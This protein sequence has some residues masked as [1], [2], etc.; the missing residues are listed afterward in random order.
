MDVPGACVEAVGNELLNGLMWTLVQAF[1]EEADDLQAYVDWDF[2]PAVI[3]TQQRNERE[4]AF[5][6]RLFFR[7]AHQPPVVLQSTPR[8]GY[9]S[10]P[11]R[12]ADHRHHRPHILG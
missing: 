4:V 10:T 8:R 2:R 3:I 6:P 7:H 11:Q 1:G 9:R 5:R 12:S